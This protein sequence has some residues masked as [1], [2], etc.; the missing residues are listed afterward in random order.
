MSKVNKL[1]VLGRAIGGRA[2]AA[3]IS[4]TTRR[5]LLQPGVSGLNSASNSKL[6][7]FPHNVADYFPPPTLAVS[8]TKLLS[9]LAQGVPAEDQVRPKKF[10]PNDVVLYQYE[11]CPFCNKVKGKHGFQSMNH[12]FYFIPVQSMVIGNVLKK[13]DSKFLF[14]YLFF[15]QRSWITMTL[16]T[17]SWR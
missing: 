9:G 14:V 15:S 16:D 10:M 1:A 8:G 7:W 11:A 2:S 12:Q 5:R 13:K 3:G 17:R 6:Q 4:G